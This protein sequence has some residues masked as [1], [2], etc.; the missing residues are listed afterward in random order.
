MSDL[1]DAA[2]SGNIEEVPRLLAPR[3]AR[4]P[5]AMAASRG[6]TAAPIAVAVAFYCVY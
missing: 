1:L 4:S 5:S 6:T 3:H 2:T